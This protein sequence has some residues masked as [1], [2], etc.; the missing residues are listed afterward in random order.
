MKN[1]IINFD[2]EEVDDYIVSDYFSKDI[3]ISDVI[4]ELSD[5]IVTY[6]VTNDDKIE[7]I[8]YELYGTPDYWDVLVLLNS[9]DPLYN[10]PT[11]YDYVYDATTS[12]VD[13]FPSPITE[14]RKQE[15]FDQFLE[16]KAEEN[17]E[18]RFI[19][20]VRESR[21]SEFVTIMKEKGYI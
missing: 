1:K 5:L 13:T 20:V 8:S 6:K 7:R 4:E 14:V 15:L 2:K 16:E 10:I 12:F 11:T 9:D 18:K 3:R 19:Y 17:E 21:L